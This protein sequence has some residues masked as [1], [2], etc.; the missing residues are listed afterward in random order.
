MLHHPAAREQRCDRA[1][2]HRRGDGVFAGLQRPLLA[3]QHHARHEQPAVPHDTG[4]FQLG[5][6]A[7]EPGAPRHH[8]D[9]IGGEWP[10]QL[11]IVHDKDGG[12]EHRHEN[13]QN[14]GAEAPHVRAPGR[15]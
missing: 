1:R 8:H 9:C 10:R 11:E 7:C 6:D 5:C 4:A 12:R 3:A 2:A 14:D 15:K 13:R